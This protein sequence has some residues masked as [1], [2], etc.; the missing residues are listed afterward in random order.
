MVQPHLD[1]LC[2]KLMHI[3]FGRPIAGLGMPP[4]EAKHLYPVYSS[5]I[6][7]SAAQPIDTVFIDG[8][9]RVA[10]ALHTWLAVDTNAVVMIHG[11]QPEHYHVVEKFYD[12][13]ERGEELVVLTPNA[14]KRADPAIEAEVVEMLLTMQYETA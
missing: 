5:A 9:F 14:A 12:V 10:C 13:L 3:N 7:Y 8:R 1:P 6:Q 4:V 11:Y 2:S